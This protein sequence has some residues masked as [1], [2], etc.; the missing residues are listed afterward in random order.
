MSDLIANAGRETLLV[1]SLNNMQLI[2]VAELMDAPG[3]CLV[4]GT[5]PCAELV[6]DATRAGM[7]ILVSSSDLT[8]TRQRLEDTIR[9]SG[10][11]G[12]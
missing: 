11:A 1:T 9:R 8:S 12:S 6:E 5:A 4:G 3:V 2:R 7:A 10:A